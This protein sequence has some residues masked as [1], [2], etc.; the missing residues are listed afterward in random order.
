M[1]RIALIVALLLLP[2]AVLAQTAGTDH[3]IKVGFTQPGDSPGFPMQYCT[4]TLKTSCV[5]GYTEKL[6]DPATANVTTQLIMAGS[7]D[8]V[9]TAITHSWSP[10]G[11]LYCGTWG[12]SIVAN[13]FD[14]KG[15]AVD[16][17]A[18]TGSVQEPCP[19]VA[20][21]AKGPLSVT[22]LP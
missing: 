1:K 8:I 2:T 16:S 14:N 13:W 19:F 7:T 10:G 11:N 12:I 21:P 17:S 15:V 6:T 22:V 3:T 20:S 18:L 9:G 4:P 5:A